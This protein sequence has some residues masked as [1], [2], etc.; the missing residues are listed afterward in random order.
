MKVAIAD[1]QDAEVDVGDLRGRARSRCRR[2]RLLHEAERGGVVDGDRARLLIDRIDLVD[3]LVRLKARV[4]AR[5]H[6]EATLRE[7]SDGGGDVDDVARAERGDYRVRDG[8]IVEREAGVLI[9]EGREVRVH[10][11]EVIRD[12][13]RLGVLR[14]QR[15]RDRHVSGERR[16]AAD[17]EVAGEAGLAGYAE[18]AADSRVAVEVRVTENVER[19][20]KIEGSRE[21][22]R[23][24]PERKR[25]AY[26]GRGGIAAAALNSKQL[27]EIRRHDAPLREP[28]DL[29]KIRILATDGSIPPSNPISSG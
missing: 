24:E 19:A 29:P 9:A 12:Q 4:E 26:G 27:R 17:G 22:E 28:W 13:N 3:A 8:L 10:V 7:A 6:E 25:V 2:E 5:D 23:R 16:V 15:A 1:L 14:D 11:K 21:I 18:R 20:R